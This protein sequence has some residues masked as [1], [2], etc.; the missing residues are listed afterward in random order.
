MTMALADSNPKISYSGW[1]ILTVAMKLKYYSSIIVSSG[2]KGSCPVKHLSSPAL[3][4]DDLNY[5]HWLFVLCQGVT[6]S[7]SKTCCI[8][9]YFNQIKCL[10]VLAALSDVTGRCD[11]M[12]WPRGTVAGVTGP[13]LWHLGHIS[14]GRWAEAD[15]TKHLVPCP[16]TVRRRCLHQ[17]TGQNCGTLKRIL[18]LKFSYF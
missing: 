7:E 13:R 10:D 6:H 5:S 14:P 8:C 17:R 11:T 18:F 2:Q 15:L 9:G 16:I 4:H 3:R 12:Q 1:Q